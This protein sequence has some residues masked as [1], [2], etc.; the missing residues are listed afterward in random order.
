MSPMSFC[1][2]IQKGILQSVVTIPSSGWDKNTKLGDRFP[3]EADTVIYAFGQEPL[4]DEAEVFRNSAP[5]YF[6]LGDCVD[7]KNVYTAN[8][9]AYTIARDL[10][11]T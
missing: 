8:S 4:R 3:F 7:A 5:Q 2:T 11:T 6:S 1:E 9:V 10:G